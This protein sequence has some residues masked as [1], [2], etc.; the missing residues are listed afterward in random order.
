MELSVGVNGEQVLIQE[1]LTRR[2]RMKLQKGKL[3]AT[4][5]ENFLTVM[6]WAGESA[7]PG[8]ARS[9]IHC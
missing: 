2:Q 7:S 8:K 9:P 4:L 3:R 1:G 5:R 6:Y